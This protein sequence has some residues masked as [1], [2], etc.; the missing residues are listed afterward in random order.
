MYEIRLLQEEELPTIIPLLRLL[1][2]EHESIDYEARLNEMRLN[3][4]ECVGV[5]DGTKLIAICGFWIL[6]KHYIGKHIEPDNVV[7]LPAYRS[8]KVGDLMMDFIH[9]IGRQR[10]C[11]VS[12]LNC[13]VRNSAGVKFWLNKGYQ[14]L[15]FH[16]RKD[17]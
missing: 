13:Y 8:K 10:G 14:I 3:N 6:Y 9:D 16:M 1:T 7:V 11:V 5:F 15:G 4:Y 17:L 12:E 2:V